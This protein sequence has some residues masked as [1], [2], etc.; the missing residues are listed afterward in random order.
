[1]ARL[2]SRTPVQ[3]VEVPGRDAPVGA[4]HGREKQLGQFPRILFGWILLGVE[5]SQGF[6]H[7]LAGVCIPATPNFPGDELLQIFW[8]RDFHG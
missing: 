5:V 8:Q 6:T 4:G 1:M 2:A 3:P 7:H